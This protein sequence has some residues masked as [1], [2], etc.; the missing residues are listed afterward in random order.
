LIGNSDL[1]PVD[2]HHLALPAFGP[3][4]ACVQHRKFV[5]AINQRRQGRFSD[6]RVKPAKPE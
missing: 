6:L 1:V 5:T 2:K 4:P 3:L